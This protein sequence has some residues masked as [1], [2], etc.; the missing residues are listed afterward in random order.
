MSV[1]QLPSISLLL[2]F[3]KYH[4]DLSFIINLTKS[5]PKDFGAYNFMSHYL[6]SRTFHF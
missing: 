6:L 5:E 2:G 3:I 1:L 4:F